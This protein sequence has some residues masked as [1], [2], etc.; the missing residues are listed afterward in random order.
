MNDMIF[1]LFR[2]MVFLSVLLP[3]IL[4]FV[5]LNHSRTTTN[6]RHQAPGGIQEKAPRV[7]EAAIDIVIEETVTDIQSVGVVGGSPV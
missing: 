6:T 1:V 4:V 2:A 7:S 3:G 5:P